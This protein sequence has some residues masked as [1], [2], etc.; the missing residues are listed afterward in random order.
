L[1]YCSLLNPALDVIYKLNDFKSGFSVTDIPSVVIPAGKG[2]NVAS[3]VKTLGEEVCVTG[4]LPEYDRK[5]MVDYLEHAGIGHNFFAV[6]GN[7]RINSTIIEQNTGYVSHISTMGE[8]VSTRLENEFIHFQKQ[9]TKADDIWSFSGS[10]VRGFD[11]AIYS[12]L[13]KVCHDA[14][15]ETML[16]TRGN[17]QKMGVR[18]K[19]LMIK[20]NLAELE[21]FFGEQIQG[22]HHI[23]LKGKRFIDMGISYVFISLGADGLIALHENDCLLCSAPSVRQVSTVGCGDALVAGIL[24]AKSRKFSF[25]EMCRMAVACGASKAMHEGPGLV[26]RDE[27]WQLM[28]EV[29]ITSV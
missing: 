28:E 13:I 19:P 6:P 8:T 21:D 27:V 20:P 5:R 11:D 25:N 14:G 4:I 15:A 7:I 23:A 16:D 10:V 22:V 24:V 12:E 29:K 17:P 1:I 3:V 9:L 18:A 26:T 2:I